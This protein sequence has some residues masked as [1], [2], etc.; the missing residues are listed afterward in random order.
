MY[1]VGKHEIVKGK[2]ETLKML[3]ILDSNYVFEHV[4]V[5]GIFLKSYEIDAFDDMI[6]SG[7]Y[8]LCNTDKTI[9]ELDFTVRTYN[10]L[11]RHGI[12]YVT[13]LI[14][15][16]ESDLMGVRNINVKLIN[17]INQKLEEMGLKLKECQ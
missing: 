4:D 6:N 11:K 5:D 17:E 1:K 8:V 12:N 14:N 13:E 2:Y 3:G 10:S 16:T 15:M 7:E 9:E